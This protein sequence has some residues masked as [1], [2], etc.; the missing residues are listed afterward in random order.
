MVGVGTR[1]ASRGGCSLDGHSGRRIPIDDGLSAERGWWLACV[2]LL[3]VVGERRRPNRAK[4]G[5]VYGW[6]LRL[7]SSSHTG[8]R[9][10]RQTGGDERTTTGADVALLLFSAVESNAA[11]VAWRCGR[12]CSG[13]LQAMVDLSGWQRWLASGLGMAEGGRR[14]TMK[15]MARERS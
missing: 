11:K 12:Q 7:S 5:G 15:M 8:G 10:W 2:L 4:A 9:R 13:W 6:L 14:F 1:Q 3:S